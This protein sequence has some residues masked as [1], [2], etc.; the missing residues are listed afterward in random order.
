VKLDTTA[1][2]IG[3]AGLILFTQA[4]RNQKTSWF[5]AAGLVIGAAVIYKHIAVVFFL[6]IAI[7]WL[8]TKGNRRQHVLVLITAGSI[9]ALY[10]L[11]M[12]IFVG[13]PFTQA[14]IVQI[15]RTLGLQEAR[16]LQYG[17]TEAF[18]AMA[19]TYWAFGGSVLSLGIGVLT[20]ILIS[21]SHRQD[22]SPLAI[23]TAWALAAFLMLGGIKLRNPHYLVYALPPAIALTSIVIV[24]LEKLHH[25][26][27][28]WLFAILVVLNLGTAIIRLA[29]FSAVNALE[30]VQTQMAELPPDATVLTE[31]SI[32]ALIAQPCYPFGHYQSEGQ[33]ATIPGGDPDYVV[34]Y[35]TTTQ[36]PPQTEAVLE[37]I[38]EGRVIYSIS[39]W[40][41]TLTIVQVES[42]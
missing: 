19:Q 32:C 33:I 1:V 40:K 34:V 25:R 13:E 14:T 11:G 31:E 27:A 9:V 12:V 29:N 24:E 21:K 8:I 2:A 18:R 15:R 23:I 16:G 7:H 5:V 35:T 36:K 28:L 4:M 39:G 41:E 17:P 30:E 3:M 22:K 20:A 10:I 26:I 6:T 37:L 42:P 38:A